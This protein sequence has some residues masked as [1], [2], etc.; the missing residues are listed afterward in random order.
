MGLHATAATHAGG[1]Y[2]GLGVHTAARISA[3]AGAGAGAGFESHGVGV[4][5]DQWLQ[6]S[7]RPE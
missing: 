6:R 4:W 3:L 2:T 7:V 5:S 1:D